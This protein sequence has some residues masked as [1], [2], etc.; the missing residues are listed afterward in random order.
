MDLSVFT[1]FV[2]SSFTVHK[3][4]I[5]VLSVSVASGGAD[6]STVVCVVGVFT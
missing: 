5:Q 6:A 3:D 2:L 4:I 1:I